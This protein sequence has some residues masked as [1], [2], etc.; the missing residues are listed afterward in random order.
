MV[1]RDV[2][3]FKVLP[4][5]PLLMLALAGSLALQGCGK[6]SDPM[7]LALPDIQAPEDS[8]DLNLADG[9]PAPEVSAPPKDLGEQLGTTEPIP[10]SNSASGAAGLSKQALTQMAVNFVRGY[11]LPLYIQFPNTS[12]VAEE[13]AEWLVGTR[14]KLLVARMA[15]VKSAPT[16]LFPLVP[17][18]LCSNPILGQ[19]AEITYVPGRYVARR[20]VSVGVVKTSSKQTE[21]MMRKDLSVAAIRE[22]TDKPQVFGPTRHVQIT[23][24]TD[25]LIA[26]STKF[27]DT[28]RLEVRAADGSMLYIS[29]FETS[30]ILKRKVTTKT[31]DIKKFG[32]YKINAREVSKSSL[33]RVVGLSGQDSVECTVSV[34]NSAGQKVDEVTMPQRCFHTGVK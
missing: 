25:K 26:Q 27:N 18:T 14:C 22:I 23:V 17:S 4:A 11:Q 1:N 34:L 31:I 12:F 5:L 29:N 10:N 15:R 20:D 28:D 7:N 24:A 2:K 21:V 6:S 19:Q 32:H 33:L 13:K 8:T 3:T 16:N 30:K 9:T